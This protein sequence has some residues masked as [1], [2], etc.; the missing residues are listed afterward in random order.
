MLRRFVP[1]KSAL[2]AR[3]EALSAGA[4]GL[5]EKLGAAKQERVEAARAAAAH[6]EAEK[7]KQMLDAD[8]ASP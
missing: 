1:R 7:V 8:R 3:A 4:A 6:P 5:S 2:R